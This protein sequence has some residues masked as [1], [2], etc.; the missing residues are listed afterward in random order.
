M[1]DYNIKKGEAQFRNYNLP[2]KANPVQLS[3][4]VT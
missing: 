4:R 2:H 3:K 1:Y